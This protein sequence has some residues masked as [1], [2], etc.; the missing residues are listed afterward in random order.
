MAVPSGNHGIFHVD[1]VFLLCPNER[2]A[3]FWRNWVRD[4]V[5]KLAASKFPASYGFRVMAAGN[6][7]VWSQ[8][9]KNG[10]RRGSFRASKFFDRAFP[11]ERT[12]TAACSQFFDWIGKLDQ[13]DLPAFSI[14]DWR[15]SPDSEGGSLAVSNAVCMEPGSFSRQ[16][17]RD[18]VFS[19][20]GV[21]ETQ[22]CLGRGLSGSADYYGISPVCKSE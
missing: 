18:Y 17:S 21:K 1:A 2:M 4:I 15:I 16:D 9:R 14:S 11:K 3:A 20:K 8:G 7:Y 12:L 19:G 5:G 10:C 6:L 22:D 13:H